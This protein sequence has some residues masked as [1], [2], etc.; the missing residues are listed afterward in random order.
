MK[1]STLTPSASLAVTPAVAQ[2]PPE[3][4]PP[5]VA[6]T[7][8]ISPEVAPPAP[9]STPSVVTDSPVSESPAVFTGAESIPANWTLTEVSD[10]IEAKCTSG[11]SFVGTVKEFSAKFGR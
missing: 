1:S 9:L 11:A 7:T 3:S 8:P 5:V 10:G 6:D 4:T 2:E